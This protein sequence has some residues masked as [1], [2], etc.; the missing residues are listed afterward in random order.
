VAPEQKAALLGEAEAERG[1]VSVVARGRG[2]STSLLYNW[3]SA[4]PDGIGLLSL[5]GLLPFIEILDRL[6][7]AA[8]P[9]RLAERGL[10]VDLLGPGVDEADLLVLRPEGDQAAQRNRW[11][12]DSPVEEDGFELP[13]PVARSL[14]SRALLWRRRRKVSASAVQP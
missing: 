7:A 2:V 4:W 12:A 11:F 14:R 3:R 9:E 5:C 10:G 6:Q 8:L 13:V 1:Q